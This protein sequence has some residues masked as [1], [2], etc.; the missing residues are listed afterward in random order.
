MR[1]PNISF[2]DGFG[3]DEEFPVSKLNCFTLES[4]HALQKH[5]LGPGEADGNNIKPFRVGEEISQLKAE[6][7]LM[8]PVGRF[9]APALHEKRRADLPEEDVRKQSDEAKPDQ[10]PRCQGRE[11]ET[12]DLTL[13]GQL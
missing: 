9:H 11:K 8:V 1:V 4:N 10:K 6:V 5:H 7:D 2:R 3:I 13:H 12:V